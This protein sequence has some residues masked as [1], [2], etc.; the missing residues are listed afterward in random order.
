[1]FKRGDICINCYISFYDPFHLN[2]TTKRAEINLPNLYLVI[3]D[4]IN[5]II[6]IWLFTKYVI[7]ENNYRYTVI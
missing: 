6:I 1:M 4:V 2:D 3:L 7:I 5:F